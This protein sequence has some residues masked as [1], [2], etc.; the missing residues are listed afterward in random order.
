MIIEG[1]DTEK[2]KIDDMGGS[3]LLV[4][5]DDRVAAGWEFKNLLNHWNRKH[6][7]AA[8]LPAL[9][10]G[11]PRQYQ[12]ADRVQLGQG[13]DFFRF[14]RLISQGSVYLDPA[15]KVENGKQK[16]RN[17]FRVSHANLPALYQSFETL[18]LSV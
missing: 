5:P 13:T 7:Q 12:Y 18:Q 15:V 10:S 1:Y 16:K 14:M 3:I 11:N 17:Q 6:A 8:Y 9:S 2:G 4:A